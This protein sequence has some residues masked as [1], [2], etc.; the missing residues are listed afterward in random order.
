MERIIKNI[1]RLMIIICCSC[2]CVGCNPQEEADAINTETENTTD[3]DDN[4]GQN[5]QEENHLA[6]ISE[7]TTGSDTLT[8]TDSSDE[9][10]AGENQLAQISDKVDEKAEPY[11]VA[12]VS[13]S[14][15]T[16]IEYC[17]WM[18]YG[19]E[20]VL[21]IAIQ[22]KEQPENDYRHKEDY[23]LF[24]TQDGDVSNIIEVNYEDKGLGMADGMETDCATHHRLGWGCD[25][26]AHFEDVT[27]DG[28]EDLLIF[29]GDGRCDRHYC[30]YIYENG[31]FRYERTFEHIPV[32]VVDTEK[33]VIC[34]STTNSATSFTDVTYKYINGEFLIIDAID[35]NYGFTN[36]ENVL[37]EIRKTTYEYINGK[38]V[39]DKTIETLDK[40][41]YEFINGENV[42][43][44]IVETTYEYEYING[45]KVLI[46][47]TV[48]I[49]APEQIVK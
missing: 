1:R 45:E 27:F 13:L 20:Q 8:E 33:E 7:N 9:T 30:A 17:K 4:A 35:T 49:V 11:I 48:N 26:D 14:D 28:E 39:L 36:G 40:Y 25:F 37:D 19:E 15:D 3:A 18:E 42:L 31:V 16:E 47:E 43:N 21:R 32:G 34:G 5:A 44:E 38:N 6:E 24:I 12:Y 29:V 23:F 10:D 22:Y 2:L 46:E 41:E